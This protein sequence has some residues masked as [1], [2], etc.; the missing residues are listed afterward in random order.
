ME[1][2]SVQQGRHWSRSVEIQM[3]HG[4]NVVSYFLWSQTIQQKSPTLSQQANLT[5]LAFL[6]YVCQPPKGNNLCQFPGQTAYVKGLQGGSRLTKAKL[7]RPMI[8]PQSLLQ[9]LGLEPS[10]YIYQANLGEKSPTGQCVRLR[11]QT[12][13]N[14]ARPKKQHHT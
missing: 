4:L 13:H 10:P 12:K 6:Y 1:A 7:N 2:K 8:T 3:P 9:G 5:R 11:A 14:H